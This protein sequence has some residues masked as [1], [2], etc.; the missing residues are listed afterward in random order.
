[1][2]ADLSALSN[3]QL[4]EE[5]GACRGRVRAIQAE[6]LVLHQELTRREQAE[7]EQHPRPDP[8]LDQTVKGL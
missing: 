7:V 2:P 4:Y 6:M 3:Q 8:S 5:M 1:M